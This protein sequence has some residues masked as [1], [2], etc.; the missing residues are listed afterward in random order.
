MPKC[1]RTRHHGFLAGPGTPKPVPAVSGA[2]TALPPTRTMSHGFPQLDTHVQ[3]QGG[4]HIQLPIPYLPKQPEPC[5]G[6]D[7]G[8]TT[9]ILQWV[10]AITYTPQTLVLSHLP[11]L[12]DIVS[13][14]FFTWSMWGGGW[15]GRNAPCSVCVSAELSFPAP[16]GSSNGSERPWPS[17][18][19]PCLLQESQF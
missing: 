6:A 7:P 5:G 19:S 1:L 10:P 3:Q 18:R 13:L 9:M 12:L 11:N 14:H 16:V 15:P 2:Q 17:A 4:K 8:G